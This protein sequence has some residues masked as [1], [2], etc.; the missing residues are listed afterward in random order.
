MAKVV[1]NREV[2]EAKIASIVITPNVV[3]SETVDDKKVVTYRN[4]IVVRYSL[5]DEYGHLEYKNV[6]HHGSETVEEL[7]DV[8]IAER[9]GI[10][11]EIKADVLLLSNVNIDS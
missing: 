9:F 10:K 4:R 2:T 1:D 5:Q 6:T 7:D 3:K 11:E 8:E